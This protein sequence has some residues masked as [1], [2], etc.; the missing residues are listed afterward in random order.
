MKLVLGTYAA[1]RVVK[2]LRWLQ[3]TTITPLIKREWE[4]VG[5]ISLWRFKSMQIHEG[6]GEL[7]WKLVRFCIKMTRNIFRVYL[8]DCC[9]LTFVYSYM[10]KTLL[11]RPLKNGE[12]LC[13][14]MWFNF[15]FFFCFARKKRYLNFLIQM[16][17][18]EMVLTSFSFELNKIENFYKLVSKSRKNVFICFFHIFSSI[19]R[20]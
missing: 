4:T 10:R 9:S 7:W 18:N 8:C 19:V 14:R 1:K 15:V 5:A 3:I 12:E 17:F 11:I 16:I 20:V 13:F 2:L 6:G